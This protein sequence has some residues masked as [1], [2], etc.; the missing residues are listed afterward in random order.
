MKRRMQQAAPEGL[1][2][3]GFRERIAGSRGRGV[4]VEDMDALFD[5]FDSDRSGHVGY[6]EI[7]DLF[8]ALAPQSLAVAFAAEG[9]E[10]ESDDASLP[11]ESDEASLSPELGQAPAPRESGEAPLHPMWGG[12]FWSAPS[13]D[14]SWGRAVSPTVVGKRGASVT[15]ADSEAAPHA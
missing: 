10:A 1:T 13:H 6:Q 4:P 15:L 12:E 3:E 11:A 5:V 14:D 2:R 8:A 9:G 7:A